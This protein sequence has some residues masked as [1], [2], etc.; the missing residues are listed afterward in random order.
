MTSQVKTVME[1]L[2]HVWDARFPGQGVLT[3]SEPPVNGSSPRGLLGV[4]TDRLMLSLEGI[5]NE[6][7]L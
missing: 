4:K 6:S 7:R 2:S 3:G 1:G 5:G